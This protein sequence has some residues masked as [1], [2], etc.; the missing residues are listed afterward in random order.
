MYEEGH[1]DSPEYLPAFVGEAAHRD[2]G[3]KLR[4]QRKVLL[5]EE[6]KVERLTACLLDVCLWKRDVTRFDVMG[7]CE[8]RVTKVDLC[9]IQFYMLPRH[10]Y[11]LR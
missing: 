5:D 6:G 1:I 7:N 9:Q 8:M 4:A 2:K 10:R 3:I 11:S